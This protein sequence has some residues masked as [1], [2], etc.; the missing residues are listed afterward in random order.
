MAKVRDRIMK[1]YLI[2][3]EGIDGE[4]VMVSY[5]NSD[6]LAYDVRYANDIQ[7]L[8]FKGIEELSTYLGNLK[9]MEGYETVRQIL[10]AAGCGKGCTKSD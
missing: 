7:T 6:A 8:N 9:K 1:P 4:N 3:C 10:S 2:L 5:L